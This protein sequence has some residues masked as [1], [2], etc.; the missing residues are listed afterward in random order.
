MLVVSSLEDV[1]KSLVFCYQIDFQGS[2]PKA[3]LVWFDG[4]SPTKGKGTSL[5]D[6]GRGDEFSRVSARG[7][8]VGRTALKE[9]TAERRVEGVDGSK[10]DSFL[11]VVHCNSIGFPH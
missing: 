11:L 8:L 2:I 10:W 5:A 4:Q 7:I 6:H 9:D 3:Q 1:R